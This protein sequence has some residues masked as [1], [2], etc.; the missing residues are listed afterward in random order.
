MMK[1]KMTIKFYFQLLIKLFRNQ[2]LQYLGQ[3]IKK[4]KLFENE[5]NDK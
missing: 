1:I 4:R 3:G 5:N 2:Y